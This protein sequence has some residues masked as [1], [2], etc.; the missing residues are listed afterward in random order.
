MAERMV[1]Y[2]P[3]VLVYEL[4]RDGKI[5]PDSS[6][7][8]R[9]KLRR[10]VDRHAESFRAALR[11]PVSVVMGSDTFEGPGT[12]ADEIVAMTR[13]GMSPGEALRS[14][15]SRGAELLGLAGRVGTVAKG[16]SADVVAFLGDPLQDIET[17][18]RP[19]LVMKE[20]KVVLD[21]R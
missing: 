14:A 16:A 10:T 12:N 17:V 8:T 21:R 7:E 11:T 6:A 9:E 15:T 3:T 1:A 19:V 4:W 18:T 5:F 13:T 20:G 2:V